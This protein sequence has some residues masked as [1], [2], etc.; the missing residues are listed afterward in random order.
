MKTYSRL[1]QALVEGW[2]VTTETHPPLQ[3]VGFHYHDVD[4][5]LEVAKGDITFF[6]IS[7][8]SWPLAVGDVFQIARG[9]VH[10]A[11]IGA[12]GVEYR[13]YLPVAMTG[14]F[15][16][17]LSDDEL[18][19]LRTNLEFPLREENTDGHAAG[20]FAEHLSDALVFCRA[21]A[22]VVD[23]QTYLSAFVARGR[24]PSGTV[25]VLNRTDTGIL[26]STVVTTGTGGPSPK[27]FTNVRLFVK[28]G[29]SWRCRLWLNYPSTG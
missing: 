21:D 25:A 23:K 26:L 6:S 19:M 10:R 4:E 11:E 15:A 8:Q 7:G 3:Q 5:W 14:G 18:A 20:F 13:M 9:E 16:Q 1:P 29:G 17:R 28:E 22:T 12:G 27:S 24:T 2:V